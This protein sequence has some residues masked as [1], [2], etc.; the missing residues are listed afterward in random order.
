MITPGSDVNNAVIG[1]DAAEGKVVL[2]IYYHLRLQDPEKKE[3]T[4]NMGLSNK[5]FNHIDLDLSGTLLT[6]NQIF[7]KQ[8]KLCFHR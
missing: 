3:I 2:K 4:V 5:Q 1:I 6:T 7:R 8:E